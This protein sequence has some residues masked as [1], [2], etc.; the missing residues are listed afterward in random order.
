MATF[1]ILDNIVVVFIGALRYDNNV[2]MVMVVIMMMVMIMIVMIKQIYFLRVSRRD[3][4]RLDLEPNSGGAL[5]PGSEGD[6]H[7]AISLLQWVVPLVVVDVF[8][9]VPDR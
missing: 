4:H 9:L 5:E 8:E 7:D 2:M 6:L 3:A 1:R